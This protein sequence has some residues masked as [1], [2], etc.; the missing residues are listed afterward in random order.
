MEEF[1]EMLVLRM[2]WLAD[3]SGTWA[4]EH[5]INILV[6]LIVAWVLRRVANDLVHRLLKRV[7]RPSVYPTKTDREKRVRTLGSLARG[8]IRLAVYAVTA[9][10]IVGELYPEGRTALFTSAGVLS[11]IIGLG[12]QSLIKDIVTGLFIITENQ[13]RIGDEV[14][15]IAGM[16][17]GQIEGQVEDLTIRTTV[18]RDLSGNVHHIPNGN[19]GVTTN[20]TL[21][22]SRMNEE[23]VVAFDT[24]LAKLEKVI[25]KVGE[26]LQAMPDMQNRIIEPP[27]L[28]G[29]K[30]FSDKGVVV[31][32]LAK[33]NAAAQWKTRSEFYRLLQKALEKN[34]I[35]LVGQ[36]ED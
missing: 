27:Y 15:L 11:V 35:K 36:A 16:G 4:D 34:R 21:G 2:E 20:K 18:L 1:T 25:K 13:Y 8:V 26:E 10:L 19:I 3:K 14:T 5:L 9:L 28:S 33:T 23:I 12:A 32:V 31:R 7:V 6:I 30:G 22:F 29:V 24:D 17:L